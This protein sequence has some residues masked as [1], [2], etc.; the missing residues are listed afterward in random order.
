MLLGLITPSNGTA[1]I[2]G[3][4]YANLSEPAREVEAVLEG[5]GFH[6]GRTA[7]DHLRILAVA[8]LGDPPVLVLDEP[9]NGLDPDVV[10]PGLRGAGGR[11]LRHGADGRVALGALI[12]NPIAAVVGALVW[13]LVAEQLMVSLIPVIGRWTPGGAAAGLLQLGSSATTHG[14]LFPAWTG[15]LVLLAYAAAFGTLA[16]TVTLRRDLT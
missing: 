7:R 12:R 1:T 14:N 15:G 13:L 9:A 5:S 2:G 11:G 6:P 3:R 10:R 16:S 4:R 8:L